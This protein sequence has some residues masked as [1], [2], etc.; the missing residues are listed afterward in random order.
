MPLLE[1][2]KQILYYVV[3]TM[4]DF[5]FGTSSSRLQGHTMGPAEELLQAFREPLNR[6]HRPLILYKTFRSIGTHNFIHPLQPLLNNITLV[7]S[8]VFL[9]TK[10]VFFPIQVL[11][12][13][14]TVKPPLMY[15]PQKFVIPKEKALLCPFSF[16]ITHFWGTYI[17]GGFTV[18]R[19]YKT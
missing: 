11:Q 18:F 1:N 15:V 16:G 14:N 3:S 6:G 8:F 9:L 4:K 2:V 17:N 7:K 13:R 5:I 12:Q 10:N 19:C